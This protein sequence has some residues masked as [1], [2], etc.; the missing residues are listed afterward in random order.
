MR[1]N[2]H[3][4]YAPSKHHRPLQV[5]PTLSITGSVEKHELVNHH[6]LHRLISEADTRNKV[7]KFEHTIASHDGGGGE[8]TRKGYEEGRGV[9]LRGSGHEG[10]QENMGNAEGA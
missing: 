7:E 3:T 4:F 6:D 9:E 5:S 10:G 8:N 1:A 2:A